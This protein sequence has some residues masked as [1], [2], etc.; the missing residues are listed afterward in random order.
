MSWVRYVLLHSR[1]H[2]GVIFCIYALFP[3]EITCLVVFTITERVT[4]KRNV[5]KGLMILATHEAEMTNLLY[6][7]MHV[8]TNAFVNKLYFKNLYDPF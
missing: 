2:R 5:L 4:H 3:I 8:L 1:V 7:C 6:M